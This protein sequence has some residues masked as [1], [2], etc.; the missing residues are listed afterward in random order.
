MYSITVSMRHDF[1]PN[2]SDTKHFL[3]LQRNMFY[4]RFKEANYYYLVLIQILPFKNSIHLHYH[5]H[6][7]TSKVFCSPYWPC[8]QIFEVNYQASLVSCSTGK[9]AL[10][11]QPHQINPRP[12]IILG[13]FLWLYPSLAAYI[14]VAQK[15]TS[16]RRNTMMS[17]GYSRIV[18]FLK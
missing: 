11:L 1:S 13:L 12:F 2:F 8:I 16:V 7:I 14:Y 18:L 4:S 17:V 15:L 5:C 9:Y 6:W 10:L 3:C